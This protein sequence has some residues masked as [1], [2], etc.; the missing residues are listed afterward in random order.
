MNL[1]TV[2]SGGNDNNNNSRIDTG[3]HKTKMIVT[4]IRIA[5][6]EVRITLAMTMIMESI[7]TQE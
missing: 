6:M 1:I 3:N 7:I 4:K 5:T 2:V